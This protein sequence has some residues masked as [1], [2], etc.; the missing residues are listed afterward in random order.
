MVRWQEKHFPP[1]GDARYLVPEHRRERFR[2]KFDIVELTE[3]GV[4]AREALL[5]RIAESDASEGRDDLLQLARMV[6]PYACERVHDLAALYVV[7]TRSGRAGDLVGYCSMTKMASTSGSVVLLGEHAWLDGGYAADFVDVCPKGT[8]AA[9]S[10][11]TSLLSVLIERIEIRCTELNIDTAVFSRPD[12]SPL[13]FPLHAAAAVLRTGSFRWKADCFGYYS[14]KT[15]SR[16]CGRWARIVIGTGRVGGREA[17]HGVRRV[18]AD[19]FLA[20]HAD[21]EA[22]AG[23]VT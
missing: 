11:E 22:F 1:Q 12:F 16:P 14:L 10:A 2:E 6:G 9:A 20:R 8:T 5:S 13:D 18:T 15:S 4:D 19:E 3:L 17:L 21:R 23:S 7:T